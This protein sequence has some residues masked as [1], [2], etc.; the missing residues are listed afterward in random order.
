MF[1]FRLFSF[2]LLLCTFLLFFEAAVDCCGF[3][4]CNPFA[5]FCSFSRFREENSIFSQRSPQ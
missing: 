4:L 3:V 5:P 2:L 1:M